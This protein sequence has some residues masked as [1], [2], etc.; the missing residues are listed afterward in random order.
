MFFTFNNTKWIENIFA[1]EI[2]LSFRYIEL[3]NSVHGHFSVRRKTIMKQNRMFSDLRYTRDVILKI[4][5]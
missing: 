3:R 2:I 1:I 5:V 4:Y